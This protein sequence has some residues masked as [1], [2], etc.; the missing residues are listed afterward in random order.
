MPNQIKLDTLLLIGSDLPLK[1]TAQKLT[2]AINELVESV[3]TVVATGTV[4]SEL[5]TFSNIDDSDNSEFIPFVEL[6]STYLTPV[7]KITALSGDKTSNMNI[8]YKLPGAPNNTKVEL[9][10]F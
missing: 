9:R 3:G 5:V 7:Y 8:T 10:R 2:S 6:S 4:S 1:T